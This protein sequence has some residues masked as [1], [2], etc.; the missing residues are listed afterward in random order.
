M[1]CKMKKQYILFE[2]NVKYTID[3]ITSY[4]YYNKIEFKNKICI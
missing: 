3:Y 1:P 4:Q 2:N